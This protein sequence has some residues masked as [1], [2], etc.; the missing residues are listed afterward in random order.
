MCAT[1]GWILQTALQASFAVCERLSARC[2]HWEEDTQKP[3]WE[4][5]C[6][7]MSNP[8]TRQVFSHR[9]WHAALWCSP[10]SVQADSVCG[11]QWERLKKAGLAP[12]RRASFGMAVHRERAV[13]FGGVTDRAGKGDKVCSFPSEHFHTPTPP[14]RRQSS[15]S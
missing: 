9:V 6:T 7:V 5:L 1:A 13:L 4:R 14:A 10:Q 15:V 2:H 12:S 11:A 8:K 3:P